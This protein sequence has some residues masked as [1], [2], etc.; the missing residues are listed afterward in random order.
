MLEDSLP[1][2][3]FH[4]TYFL[5]ERKCILTCV[6]IVYEVDDALDLSSF[7]IKLIGETDSRLF[8]YLS[9]EIDE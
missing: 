3:H 5:I 7:F 9:Q 2:F 6:L 4:S 1:S 8:I